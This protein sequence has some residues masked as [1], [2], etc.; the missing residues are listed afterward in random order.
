MKN[1][2]KNILF[3]GTV[4]TAGVAA[5]YVLAPVRRKRNIEKLLSHLEEIQ[6]KT[7]RLHRIVKLKSSKSIRNVSDKV[8]RE[9]KEPI[10]DLYKATDGLMM[11]H[12]DL[13]DG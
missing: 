8:K 2:T 7:Q 5:G 9:L 13:P 3:A 12:D 1:R 10:P 4:F 6:G 11:S